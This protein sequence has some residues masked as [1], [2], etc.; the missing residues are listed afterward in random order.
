MW[1][2]RS[3]RVSHGVEN[4]STR[5]RWRVSRPGSGWDRVGPRR[6]RPR[7]DPARPAIRTLPGA[8]ECHVKLLS[9]MV[10]RMGGPILARLSAR[11]PTRVK[12]DNALDHEH[13]SAPTITGLLPAASPPRRLRGVL[14][15]FVVGK[16][17]LERASHLDAFSGSPS[18]ALLPGGACC[19]TTGP[20]AASPLRSS[21]T[22]S[23]PPHLPS[24]HSG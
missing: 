24:A 23:G 3:G 17:I 1:S 19:H 16:V 4:R 5:R 15:T 18:E 13:G 14:P 7:A 6:P 9:W 21:R 20:Q 11:A 8:S 2:A 22:R 12:E 10:A